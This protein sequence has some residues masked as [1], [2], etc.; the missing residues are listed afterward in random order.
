MYW[1][2]VPFD[3]VVPS[4]PVFGIP[5]CCGGAAADIRAKMYMQ[6]CGLFVSMLEDGTQY[7]ILRGKLYA[8]KGAIFENLIAD[9]F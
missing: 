2:P 4:P 9:I 7:Y 8:Y 5:T 6:D 3:T 1:S